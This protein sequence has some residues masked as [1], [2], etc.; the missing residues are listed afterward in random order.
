MIRNAFDVASKA[1]ANL[2]VSLRP[3]R[4]QFLAPLLLVSIAQAQ[5]IQLDRPAHTAKQNVALIDDS[6]TVEAGKPDE[7]ELRFRV[8][9]G[10]HIN[11]HTPKD[12]LL[13][14]T[15][16]QLTGTNGVSILGEEFP[17]GEKLHLAI[18]A[19]EMLNVYQGEFRVLLRVK[20]RA[21]ESTLTGALHYQA[22]DTASCY[23]PR[24]LPV[25]IVVT[26]K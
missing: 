5:T 22:C 7:L 14:P 3:S 23:P 2:S 6:A 1:V 4:L 24:T 19:G 26:A 21:G 25:N 9:P 13:L 20:A 8:Q 16:L 11:S 12:E 15:T 18:G 10:M 17:A